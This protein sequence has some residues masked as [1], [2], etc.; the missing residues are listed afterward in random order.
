MS[1]F[2]ARQTLVRVL[3]VVVYVRARV[4]TLVESRGGGGDEGYPHARR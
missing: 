3:A 4:V 1:G 2:T